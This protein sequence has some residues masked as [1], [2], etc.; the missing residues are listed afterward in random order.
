MA[1]ITAHKKGYRAQVRHKDRRDSAVFSTKAEAK[2]WAAERETEFRRLI[3]DGVNTEKTIKDCFNRYGEEVSP[4][5]KGGVWEVKRLAAIEQHLINGKKLGAMLLHEV[6]A[7]TLGRWRDMRLAEGV[8]GSTVNRDMS[9]LSHVFT[10][11]R[12]EWK[13]I[14]ASPTADVR[15]PANPAARDRRISQDEIDRL[16]LAIGYDGVVRSQS[17]RVMVAFLF[18]IETAMRAGEICGLTADKIN[19]NVATLP[20]TKNG[21]KRDVALSSRAV[22]LLKTLPE[23]DTCFGLT[24]Q[25]LDALFRKAKKKAGVVDLKFHDTR[26][27]AI[28][29]LAKKLTILELARMV[30]HRDL[31]MLQIYFNATADEIAKKLD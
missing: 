5:K 7:D 10:T 26:H 4:S 30:G 19:G 12:R 3:K 21:T 11:A 1:S 15:R 13:W 6:T 31:G 2:A 24:S 18:A 22:E 16:A 29:R 9:L 17:D 27:E 20:M 25:Q 28:T 23:G 8:S 14:A